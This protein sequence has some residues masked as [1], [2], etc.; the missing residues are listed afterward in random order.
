M[1]NNLQKELFKKGL[2]EEGDSAKINA[3]KKAYRADYAKDYNKEF[4]AKTVRKTLIFSPDEFKYLE[5]QSKIYKVKLSPFLKSLIFAYLNSSFIFPEKETLTE[6]E[7]ILR[8]INRRIAESIQYIHL[9]QEIKTSD[10]ESL[11]MA[12]TELEKSVLAT[13]KNPPR[14]E[15]W[16]KQQTEKDDLFLPQLLEKIAKFLTS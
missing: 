14:L 6:I 4:N 16:L 12:I 13:L 15:E 7:N 5:E 8:E 2:I 11:K 9:S 10:I 3:F 1:K